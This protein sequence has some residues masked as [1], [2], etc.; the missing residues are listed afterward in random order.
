MLQVLKRKIFFLLF[1]MDFIQEVQKQM[2]KLS[3]AKNYS[4]NSGIQDRLS[5][6]TVK[7]RNI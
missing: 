1:P 2:Q 5:A 3:L 4:M 7:I 6:M